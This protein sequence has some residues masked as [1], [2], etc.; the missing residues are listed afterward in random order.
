MNVRTYGEFNCPYSGLYF[1]IFQNEYFSGDSFNKKINKTINDYVTSRQVS[2]KLVL[3]QKINPVNRIT[4]NDIEKIKKLKLQSKLN[5]KKYLLSDF[6]P[7]CWGYNCVSESTNCKSHSNLFFGVENISINHELK[8]IPDFD[9]FGF[10]M[11]LDHIK[12]P[13]QT[14]NLILEKSK[15]VILHLHTSNTLL[16]KQ[17]LFSFS[18]DFPKYLKSN[19]IFN[20]DITQFIKKDNSR[21]KGKNYLENQIYLICSKSKELI[22]SIK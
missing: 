13:M 4:T 15:Y 10:F 8:N 19:K 2:K 18:K 14:L 7:L 9:C 22:S 3:K 20:L 17:H 21:N 11:V 1:N 16:T 12:K 6:S 5:I